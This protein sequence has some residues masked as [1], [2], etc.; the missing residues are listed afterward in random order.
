MQVIG[1]F[2]NRRWYSKLSSSNYFAV[3]RPGNGIRS[4]TVVFGRNFDVP[5]LTN[6][7]VIALRSPIRL[8]G[9]F[10][11]LKNLTPSLRTYPDGLTRLL[12]RLEL[13]GQNRFALLAGW[14]A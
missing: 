5:S 2:C 3:P 6:C 1:G 8:N 4:R 11:L 9:C 7:P 14:H 12:R 10:D 13:L